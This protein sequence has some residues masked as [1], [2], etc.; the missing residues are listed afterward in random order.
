MRAPLASPRR[1]PG[2]SFL[3]SRFARL[4]T[5]FRRYDGAV[6]DARRFFVPP[7]DGEGGEDDPGLGPGEIPPGGA[8]AR[9]G[10][11][12]TPDAALKGV[13]GP[14][15]EGGGMGLVAASQQSP[16]SSVPLLPRPLRTI[17]AKRGSHARQ[18]IDA[19]AVWAEEG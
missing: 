6:R 11:P 8:T 17:F 4:D 2:S 15:L 16:F 7:L 12:P 5:G 18:V 9:V 13:V 19:S 10:L 14:P 1:K 3:I